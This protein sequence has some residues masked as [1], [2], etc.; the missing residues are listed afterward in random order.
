[1]FTPADTHYNLYTTDSFSMTAGSHVIS[2]VGLNPQG[3]DNTAFLD[4]VQI[5]KTASNRISGLVF[6]D[7]NGNGRQDPGEPPLRNYAVEV[8]GVNGRQIATSGTDATPGFSFDN[9]ADGSSL[10]T[11]LPGGA[12]QTT[13]VDADV[14][15]TAVQELSG[16]GVAVPA[17]AAFR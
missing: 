5:T 16:F 1:T 6:S 15:F 3:G 8:I 7:L 17:S 10:D 12:Q 14:R 11:L 4:D 13:P 2:F 9:V